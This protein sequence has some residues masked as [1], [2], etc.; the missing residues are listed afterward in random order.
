M[1]IVLKR[2]NVR[3][4]RDEKRKKISVALRLQHASQTKNPEQ[5]KVA[6]ELINTFNYS[7]LKSGEY[8][9]L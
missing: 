7:V 5:Q 6:Q 4:V 2:R 3:D 9:L 8:T 1:V